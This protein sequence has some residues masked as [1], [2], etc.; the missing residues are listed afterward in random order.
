M[1][2]KQTGYHILLKIPTGDSGPHFLVPMKCNLEA[3]WMFKITK[4]TL[5][6]YKG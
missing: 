2:T 5:K 3:I 6:Q 1:A 4:I